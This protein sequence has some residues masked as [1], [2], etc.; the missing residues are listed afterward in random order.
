[1]AG[2]YSVEQ[3][4]CLSSIAKKFGFSDYRAI[5]DHANNAEFRDDRPNPNIICKGDRIYIPDREKKDF[6]RDHDKSHKFVLKRPKAFLKAVIQYDGTKACA[7]CAY[8]VI[9]PY[10]EVV[11]TTGDDGLIDQEIPADLDQAT[12][13]VTVE[14]DGRKTVRRWALKLGHLDPINTPTGI[15]ARLNNLGFDC[16]EVDGVIGKKTKAAI[17]DFQEWA[18]LDVD[19]IAGPETQA[20]LKSA[21]GC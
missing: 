19:G 8:R 20:K 15:Q 14:D 3:G 12:L 21:Y 13:E 5:Y 18:G 17:E 7:N 9:F 11:G 10:G 2:Y 4:D 6:D 16:G 1:M